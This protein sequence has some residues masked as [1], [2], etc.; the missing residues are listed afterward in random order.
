VKGM[1]KLDRVIDVRRR[2]EDVLRGHLAVTDAEL[3]R[4]REA[5]AALAGARADNHAGILDRLGRGE[6]DTAVVA[7]RYAG[8]LLAEAQTT[9]AAAARQAE[10]R[11]ADA[12]RVV[13][14]ARDRLAVERARERRQAEARRGAARVETRRLDEIGVRRAAAHAL[15]REDTT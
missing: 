7:Q 4:L 6:I 15:R 8:R 5:L 10:K 3:Q 12:R 13:D 14:A 1:A 11:D 9:Q 2:K